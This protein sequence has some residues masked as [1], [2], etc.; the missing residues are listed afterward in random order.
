[1]RK[2]IY[3]ALAELLKASSCGVQHISLWN[4]KIDQLE[5]E[6]TF[7]MPAVFIEFGDLDWKQGGNG[8]KTATATITLHIVMQTLADPAVG[9]EYQQEALQLF[10]TIDGIIA[11]VERKGGNCFNRL[12]H[13][14]STTDHDHGEVLH[15]TEVFVCEVTDTRR[16]PDAVCLPN[17]TP[18]INR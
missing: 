15:Y 8:A 2:E 9:S 13:V 4:V 6:P 18:T 17:G 10:D 12:Q 16:V 14:R 11:A 7:G 1:M 5:D 3:L